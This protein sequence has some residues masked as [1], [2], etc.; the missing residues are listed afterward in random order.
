MIKSLALHKAD[1]TARQGRLVKKN[2]IKLKDNFAL[3]VFF[4]FCV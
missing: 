1:Q 3:Q 2:F 4:S